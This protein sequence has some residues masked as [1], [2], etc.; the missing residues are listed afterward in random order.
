MRGEHS[1]GV[2]RA[3][4]LLPSCGHMLGQGGKVTHMA[5][6]LQLS[7]PGN[8]ESQS[9]TGL[10]SGPFV[11]PPS[12]LLCSQSSTASA[13]NIPSIPTCPS[14]SQ[15]CAAA[16]VA[17]LCDVQVAAD[18]GSREH[19]ERALGH[20]PGVVQHPNSSSSSSSCTN[21]PRVPHVASAHTYA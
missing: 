4:Q 3:R 6:Q 21:P 15:S 9:F 11:G 18:G 20:F 13:S 14:T 16:A 7:N 17:Q 10:P 2:G 5:R 12:P 8:V 19:N 1:A